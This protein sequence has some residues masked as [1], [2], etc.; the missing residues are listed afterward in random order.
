MAKITT[1]QMNKRTQLIKETLEKYSC[2]TC[3]QLAFL[4]KRDCGESYTPQSISAVLRSFKA[5]GLAASS[6]DV[7]GNTVYWMA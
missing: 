1:E 2:A 6:K 7:N 3:K 4:I 5:K